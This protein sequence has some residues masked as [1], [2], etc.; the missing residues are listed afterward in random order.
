MVS[1]LTGP[2]Q[3]KPTG[4]EMSVWVDSLRRLSICTSSSH[5]PRALHG[6]CYVHAGILYACL[7][8]F[9]SLLSFSPCP[10]SD[11]F[12]AAVLASKVL[13]VYYCC[14]FEA[15]GS[16]SGFPALTGGVC[17]T[18]RRRLRACRPRAEPAGAWAAVGTLL[19]LPWPVPLHYTCASLH[20]HRHV[21]MSG[22]TC[23]RTLRCGC[24]HMHMWTHIH[25]LAHIHT[26]HTHHYVNN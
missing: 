10:S 1:L 18:L 13:F 25:N 21:C 6:A 5:S 14:F 17:Q 19:T 23:T 15:V 24:T 7:L 4:L 3:R 16:G 20:S 12:L 8:D 22:L 26:A 9:S 2:G 11:H